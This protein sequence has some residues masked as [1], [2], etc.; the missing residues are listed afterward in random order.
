MSS[1][2][3]HMSPGLPIMKDGDFAGLAVLQREYGFVGIRVD[4]RNRSIVMVRAETDT[5]EEVESVPIEQQ[6]VYLQVDCDFRKRADMA[7]FYYSLDGEEWIKIGKQH[8]MIYTLPHFMGYLFGLF[9]FATMTHGG[10]ADFDYF[11]VGAEH[12]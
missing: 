10:S 8:Q 9:N 11:R 2:T 3:V 6:V 1:T 12:F 7:H 4:G 5:L